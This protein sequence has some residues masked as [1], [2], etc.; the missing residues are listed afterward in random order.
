MM[1][2]FCDLCEAEIVDGEKRGSEY[3]SIHLTF[4]LHE[5]YREVAAD[6]HVSC[7]PEQFKELVALKG[8][9]QI[10]DADPPR[11]ETE[12]CTPGRAYAGEGGSPGVR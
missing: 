5:E 7:T 4:Y 11:A 1:R 12:A 6:L 2:R 8:K 10:K 9:S 3:V